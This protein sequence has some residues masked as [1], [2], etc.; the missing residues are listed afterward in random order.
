[1]E[2]IS[3]AEAACQRLPEQDAEELRAEVNILLQRAKPPKS[4]ITKEEK[5]VLKEL[6]EYEDRMVF[7]ED[8]GVAMVVMDRKE[9]QEKVGNL[10]AS[11]AYKSFLQTSPIKS[12]CS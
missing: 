2:Y 5:K 8:K 10:L 7:T 9:Y 1:M 11:S 6:R 12:R 4:N 3:A